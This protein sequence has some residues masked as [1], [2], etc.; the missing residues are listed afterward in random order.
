MPPLQK[1]SCLGLAATLL[2]VLGAGGGVCM[3]AR[4]YR[5]L[6]DAANTNLVRAQSARNNLEALAGEQGRKLGELVLAGDLRERTA[7]QVQAKA[8]QEAQPDYAAANQLLRE[9]TGGDPAQAAEA[10]INQE[11]G[12]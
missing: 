10:I 9:R 11:L 7:T 8:E 3:A 5:P 2:L 4:H 12:L 1:L 6:L